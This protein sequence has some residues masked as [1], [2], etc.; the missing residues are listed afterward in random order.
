[1]TVIQK[2]KTQ[3]RWE[4]REITAVKV[5][6]L[7]CLVHSNSHLFLHLKKHLDSQKFHD[8]EELINEVNVFAHAGGGVLWHWNTKTCTRLN[9]CLDKGRT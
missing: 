9:L 8:D 3:N 5:A 1:M 4:G 7:L 2:L 6:I